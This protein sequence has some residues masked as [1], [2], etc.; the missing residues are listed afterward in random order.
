MNGLPK[1]LIRV[2]KP[3]E[4]VLKGK[5]EEIMDLAS[6]Y[7]Y[8]EYRND[9][10]P[11]VRSV[12]E[13]IEKS[14]E[15]RVL[16]DP[17]EFFKRTHLSDKM[18][19]LLYKIYGSLAGKV[20]VYLDNNRVVESRKRVYLLPSLLG[21]GKTHLLILT[22][23]IGLLYNTSRNTAEIT[24]KLKRIDEKFAD[25]M[26]K[27]LESID[28]EIRIAAFA[29]DHKT[30]APRPTN[31]V[32]LGGKTI[33]TPWGLLFYQLGVYDEYKH[34]DESAE[35]PGV[36]ELITV[37]KN[38]RTLIL[39][40]EPVTYV[41]NIRSSEFKRMFVNYL[42][43]LAQ[44]VNSTP[45]A[46]LVISIPARY[47]ET[48]EIEAEQDAEV[49]HEIFNQ[50]MR[51]YPEIISPLDLSKDLSRVLIR[52]I[53][54][55]GEEER[56]KQANRVI[57]TVKTHVSRDTELRRSIEFKYKDIA[58]FLHRLRSTYP[59]HP[60]FIEYLLELAIVNKSL[61]RT[62]E[63]VGLAAEIV[64]FIY[65]ELSKTP[66]ADIS[67]IPVWAIPIDHP[68]IRDKLL[69]GLEVASDFQRIYS[70]DVVKH[71]REA[72]LRDRPDY[73][74]KKLG[75]YLARTVWLT[76]I[77][78]YGYR[79]E[80][81]LQKYPH[82]EELPVIMYEPSTY[83]RLGAAADYINAVENLLKVS[84][85]MVEDKGRIFYAAIPD[86]TTYVR[87]KYMELGDQDAAMELEALYKLLEDRKRWK[88]LN[89]VF[90]KVKVLHSVYPAIIEAVRREVG[91]TSDPV[92]VVYVGFPPTTDDL[93]G[94]LL[95]NNV[96]LLL[97]DY[98]LDISGM[99]SL[100]LPSDISRLVGSSPTRIGDLIKTLLKLRRA[101]RDIESNREFLAET[102]GEEYVETA[103]KKLER[104][105][106]RVEK[107]LGYA[108]ISSLRYILIGV[109]RQK[110]DLHRGITHALEV[111]GERIESMLTSIPEAVASYLRQQGVRTEWSFDELMDTL[112]LIPKLWDTRD[113]L[114]YNP[115]IGSITNLWEFLLKT[116]TVP[117]HLTRKKQ[118]IDV[119]LDG[120][121][122][123]QLAFT[124]GGDVVWIREPV[125]EDMIDEVRSE[126]NLYGYYLRK[127]Y[128]E[129][130]I[131]HSPIPLGE[132]VITHPYYIVDSV[133][134]KI[135]LMEKPFKSPDGRRGMKRIYILT[136]SGEKYF[137]EYV[138]MIN[139]K[140][141]LVDVLPRSII[142][143][144]VIFPRVSYEV[145]I[146]EV[147]GQGYTGSPVSIVLEK[148]GTINVRGVL[149]SSEY[150]YP[151][152]LRLE[153]RSIDGRVVN[154]VEEQFSLGGFNISINVEEPGEYLLAL[155]SRGLDPENYTVPPIIIANIKLTGKTCMIRGFKGVEYRG[156]ISELLDKYDEVRIKEL[157]FNTT[158]IMPYI[159]NN[160]VK[161]LGA[162]LRISNAEAF[163]R[164][165]VRHPDVS[166]VSVSADKASIMIAGK[167]LNG[168]R[169]LLIDN[170]TRIDELMVKIKLPSLPAESFGEQFINIV[171]DPVGMGDYT[172]IILELCRRI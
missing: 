51:S 149:E 115:E 23:Y 40:D 90:E 131:R 32:V 61:G 138:E 127:E 122:R 43:N 26:V 7:Y 58:G 13:S 118:F 45:G 87:T 100:R 169:E 34:L 105:K 60:F 16:M 52:R 78:G 67:L 104:I 135:I 136:D 159:Y 143:Y 112:K 5:I 41:G 89:Q 70:E 123:N 148:P 147:G 129:E 158:S 15:K 116:P 59:Y 130:K 79:G 56:V 126:K 134:E 91:E 24:Y 125:H 97:R 108:L 66:L 170:R 80:Q 120:Y 28:G 11:Q 155:N 167:L 94:L 82:I 42:R 65:E 17:V 124:A 111:M 139:D 107:L 171:S 49:V 64:R 117:P 3:H 77:L 172:D 4:E 33:K 96:V 6:V 25:K 141:T 14:I 151:I 69:A 142:F 62:R 55:V 86:I 83:N 81:Y 140:E 85:Y 154:S 22:Y 157:V 161:L 35:P 50:V 152:R 1:P 102:V 8:H 93:L 98:D 39:V 57:E 145:K 76:S 99:Q 29:G 137:R 146:Y 37:L 84:V 156:V 103:R 27:L 71:S 68:N 12:V 30:L 164:I 168:F 132:W 19:L 121:E 44:A 106:G 109:S 53:F 153:L 144:R 20:N 2:L 75:E 95:R 88:L 48:G 18:K 119:L 36:D 9:E 163:I 47:R 133:V 46:V 113:R 92:L 166:E 63:L 21:G 74:A 128:L 150:P 72:N 114:T 38:R 73:F 101:I 31:P 110:Y 160:L 10:N 162:L 54:D 165:R